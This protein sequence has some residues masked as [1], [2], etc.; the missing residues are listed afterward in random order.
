MIL[1]INSSGRLAHMGESIRS[2][3]VRD[4]ETATND[5]NLPGHE[6]VQAGKARST[7]VEK[8]LR[9][10]GLGFAQVY[11][12]FTSNANWLLHRSKG[13]EYNRLQWRTT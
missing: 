3:G 9:N 11:E 2:M 1:P 12:R 10:I 4:V 8:L 13:S 7:Q 6:L 5:F